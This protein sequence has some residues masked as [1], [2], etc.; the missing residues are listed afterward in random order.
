MN[1]ALL[2]YFAELLVLHM[3]RICGGFGQNSS[4]Y[5]AGEGMMLGKFFHIIIQD[6]FFFLFLYYVPVI[7][8]YH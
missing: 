5:A 1:I 2:K 3:Q 6:F 8:M 4:A 7:I